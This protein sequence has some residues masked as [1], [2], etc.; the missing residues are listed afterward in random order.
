MSKTILIID[1]NKNLG[2][3]IQDWLKIVFPDCAI[4]AVLSG[5]DAI[6]FFA[7]EQPNIVIMDINLSGING[8][9][10]TRQLK[11]KYPLT[12]I[13]FLSFFDDDVHRSAAFSV[14]ASGYVVKSKINIDFIPLLTKLISSDERKSAPAAS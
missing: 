7:I 4:A 8:I 14:G 6:D 12:K 1:D 5:V 11:N 2:K 9:E 3:I 13:I 10:A